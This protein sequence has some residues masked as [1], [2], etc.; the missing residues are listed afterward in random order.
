VLAPIELGPAL[1][2][3]ERDP[4]EGLGLVIVVTTTP[5]SDAWRRAERI[6]D[7]TLT[8]VGVFVTGGAGARLAVDASTVAGFRAGWQRLAGSRSLRDTPGGDARPLEQPA[9]SP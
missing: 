8:R 9:A 4:S 6:I 3:I 2:E 5:D 1:D 7:P